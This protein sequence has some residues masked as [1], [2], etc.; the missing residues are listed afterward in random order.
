M[1]KFD[2]F[3]SWLGVF[4][5]AGC[6]V[7]L[8]C[9]VGYYFAVIVNVAGV[10]QSW[11]PRIYFILFTAALFLVLVCLVLYKVRKMTK[12]RGKKRIR[13]T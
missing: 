5:V 2:K 13:T 3:L 4:A 1:I 6:V 11:R 8:F 9:I 7:G 12:R 10:K